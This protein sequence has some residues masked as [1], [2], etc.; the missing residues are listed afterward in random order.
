LVRQRPAGVV[1]AHLWEFP[2]LEVS[3]GDGDPGKAAAKLF[4]H[5]PKSVTPI[6]SIRHSI[7]RYRIQL[8]VFEANLQKWKPLNPVLGSWFKRS[9]LHR[10][11]FAGA[12]KRVLEL[13]RQRRRFPSRSR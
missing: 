5:A 1:N 7:T 3:I 6:C 4:R 13:L 2:N 12:H 10:L 9:Q 8:D 11:A